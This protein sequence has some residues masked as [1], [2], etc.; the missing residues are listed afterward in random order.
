[1][2]AGADATALSA[3]DDEARLAWIQGR[4]A[5]TSHRATRWLRG[6]E[7]GIVGATAA[8]LA[9]I[10]ILGDSPS[11]RIDFGLGAA[12]TIIGIVPFLFWRPRVLDDHLELDDAVNRRAV[13]RCQLLEDAEQRL[14]ANAASQGRQRAWYMHAGNVVL[15]ASVTFL[16]GAFHHWTSG[17]L[18]GIGGALVGEAIIYTEPVDQIDD[19]AAYRRGELGA[20]SH[21]AWR[22]EPIVQPHAAGL[23]LA[24]TFQ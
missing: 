18:N 4:L 23:T 19:L 11:N 8:D 1:M 20:P 6:W 22:L 21:H 5:R 2:M 12:T 10:P 16:F 15:N 17:I 3:H 24:V 7:I 13:D 14:R 9:M